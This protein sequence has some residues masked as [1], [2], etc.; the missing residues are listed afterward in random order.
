MTSWPAFRRSIAIGRM[1]HTRRSPPSRPSS[2]KAGS[3]CRTRHRCRHTQSFASRGALSQR[4][5]SKLLCG[6]NVHHATVRKSY[7]GK[8]AVEQLAKSILD[9]PYSRRPL[10]QVSADAR[11]YLLPNLWTN[12]MSRPR[13]AFTDYVTPPVAWVPQYGWRKRSGT[14][15]TIKLRPF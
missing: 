10:L 1:F 15:P 12:I 5:C 9:A 7:L 11:A 14:L 13:R 3:T 8:C 2:P 6:V 4:L